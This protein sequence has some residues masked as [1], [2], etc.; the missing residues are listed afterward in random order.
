M[1]K[2]N[3]IIIVCVFA[4][5]LFS[6]LHFNEQQARKLVKKADTAYNNK[7]YKLAITCYE[8]AISI[9]PFDDNNY[10]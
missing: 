4:P 9:N 10:S 2:I 6:C 8:K 5:T 3:V 7:N 1:K